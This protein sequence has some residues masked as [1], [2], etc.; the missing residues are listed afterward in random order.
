MEKIYSTFAFLLLSLC[1]LQAQ[2]RTQ[3]YSPNSQFK[4]FDTKWSLFSTEKESIIRLPAL[5]NDSLCYKSDS[6]CPARFGQGLD[7]AYTLSDGKWTPCDSGRVWTMTFVSPNA[8]SLNFIFNGLFLSEGSELYITNSDNSVIYG[9]ITSDAIINNELF[10]TDI[11][12][13]KEATIYLF[14]PQEMRGTTSLTIERVI[15]G[16]KTVNTVPSKSITETGADIACYPEYEELAGGIPLVISSDGEKCYNGCLLMSTD[17]SFKPYVL[18]DCGCIDTD[19]NFILSSQEKSNTSNLVFKFLSKRETCGGATL[20]TSY[21]YNGSTYKA[22]VDDTLSLW[23]L[24]EINNSNLK[25]QSGITWLGWDRNT[26]FPTSGFCIMH[27]K[28]CNLLKYSSAFYNPSEW[29]DSWRFLINGDSFVKS[30]EGFPLF[31]NGKKTIGIN[32]A[33]NLS[34]FDFGTSYF[35]KF[36]RLWTGGG[37]ND[38]RLSNWLD[39]I[40]TN[41]LAMESIQYNDLKING[42]IMP[43]GTEV[44]SIHD[45]PDG[46]NVEW[47]LTNPN[48]EFTDS[49]LQNIPSQNECTINLGNGQG[50]CETLV[51]K[52]K[53]NNQELITTTHIICNKRLVTGT[54]S[55]VGNGRWPDIS[56][57]HFDSGDGFT[58][59]PNCEVTITSPAF[60]GTQLSFLGIT[61]V[62]WDF[63]SID[64]LVVKYPSPFLLNPMA[65]IKAVYPTSCGQFTIPI[66][67]DN[68]FPHPLLLYSVNIQGQNLIITDNQEDGMIKDES[69][70]IEIVNA[71][72][73]QCVYNG[74]LTGHY[75]NVSTIGWKPG[76]YLISC[77]SKEGIAT[78]KIVIE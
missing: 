65:M 58:I 78:Q 22:C 47:S 64:T 8:K 38:T 34:F 19:H 53:R 76:I 28:P 3:Y 26:T 4:L 42:E 44:Y 9:P 27:E 48:S 31:T 75:I 49:L 14:E 23:I 69:M 57:T 68:H 52:I 20:A 51:A 67:I 73:G 70:D 36:G 74:T 37:T 29:C 18:T 66:Q 17:L 50:I 1:S 16:F 54:Y 35:S 77:K 71:T 32:C 62:S 6:I 45:L 11:I 41:Q 15:H 46:Y 25:Y 30:N 24:V 39:P 5:N 43:C 40:G 10:I 33:H 21:T 55:Q 63:N 59:N 56:E 61:P 12:P 13:G 7:V 60:N 72:T 2:V